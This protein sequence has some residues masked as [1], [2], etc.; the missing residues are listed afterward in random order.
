MPFLLISLVLQVALV[1]H[2]VKTGRNTTW[3]WIVVMLP[4]AGSIAYL[5]V[6]VLPDISNSKTGR[7]AKRSFSK[8][9][10]PNKDLKNAASAFSVSDTVENTMKLAGELMQKKMYEDAKGL[11]ERC[12]KGVHSTDPYIMFGLAKAKFEL[13]E[14]E[15]ALV[16]MDDLKEHN[17]DFKNPEAHL[18]Y[19]RI[20]EA[21][22]Q[23]EQALHEYEV[24]HQYY[25]GPEASYRYAL[26]CRAHGQQELSAQLLKGIVAK[27]EASGRHYKSL[28][29]EWIKLAK[30]E[31]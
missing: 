14:H 6:E 18:L 1:L 8:T 19:A 2:I 15:A 28:H 9:V 5:I 20:Q 22:G 30:A 21:L 23:A 27:S 29:R 31:I 25:P 26:F 11:Y 12:L 13:G 4:L 16:L 10:N 7:K 17:P 24:L 3:I